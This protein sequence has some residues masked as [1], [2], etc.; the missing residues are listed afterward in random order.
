MRLVHLQNADTDIGQSTNYFLWNYA[1]RFLR[2][3]LTLQAR[4]RWETGSVLSDLATI[5]QLARRQGDSSVALIAS[6]IEAMVYLRAHD[7]ESMS[8][9]QRAIATARGLEQSAGQDVAPQVKVLI[10]MLD[11][12]CSLDPYDAAR[13]KTTVAAMQAVLETAG[14][15]KSYYMNGNIPITVGKNAQVSG[16]LAQDSG[17]I[18]GKTVSG[19]DYLAMSWLDAADSFAV[20]FLLSAIAHHARNA[21]EWRQTEMFIKEGLKMAQGVFQPLMPLGPPN[22]IFTFPPSRRTHTWRPC[23]SNNHN[24]RLRHYPPQ[25]SP[26][27]THAPASHLPLR[28]YRAMVPSDRLTILSRSP[29]PPPR[30]HPTAYSPCTLHLPHRRHRP[31]HRRHRSRPGRLPIPPAPAPP[32]LTPRPSKRRN[33]NTHPRRTEHPPHTQILHTLPDPAAHRSPPRQPRHLLS[34]L[35][36]NRPRIANT[37]QPKRA[38]LSRTLPHPLHLRLINL[39]PTTNPNKPLFPID[40]R[41]QILAAALPRP[42]QADQQRPP[43]RP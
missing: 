19:T 31:R 23:T 4:S 36:P 9:V 35:E 6:V 24:P 25:T 14:R 33:H 8:E 12:A 32:L 3:S 13:A 39:N 18:F 5:S 17:N 34:T 27:R 28:R 42:Q 7:T 22:A 16:T 20:G 2:V 11:L 1:F 10:L 30:R 40:P 15:D 38:P 29:H 37:L 41:H 21:S 26:T 43:P